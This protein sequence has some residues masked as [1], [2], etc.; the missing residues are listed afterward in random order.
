M[1]S[2]F[3]R[4]VGVFCVAMIL[5]CIAG[6]ARAQY[7]EA[8]LQVTPPDKHTDGSPIVNAITYRWEKQSGTAWSSLATTTVPTYKQTGLSVGTHC[9][10]ARAIVNGVQSEPSN[11]G[12]KTVT[13]P[14]PNP[15]TLTVIETVAGYLYSPVFPITE[16]GA[17]S[18]V[19]A[20]LTKVG[21]PCEGP[22]LFKYQG[23]EWKKPVRWR[24]ANWADQ[25]LKVA[26][27]C[28]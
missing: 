25:S 4:Y 27:P 18:T 9:Y 1:K 19:F 13:Q 5:M 8:V 21:S 15:P 2:F 12:C 24:A 11:T 6:I 17:R 23:I 20:G 26:A 10:R 28:S 14:A 16:S 22:T 3:D 7:N